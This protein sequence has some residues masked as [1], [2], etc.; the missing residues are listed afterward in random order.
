MFPSTAKINRY[1]E[2]T[3]DSPNFKFRRVRDLKWISLRKLSAKS[4]I[5]LGS[6]REKNYM[7]G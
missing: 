7:Q 6:A 5:M 1:H 3:L 2:R 4:L